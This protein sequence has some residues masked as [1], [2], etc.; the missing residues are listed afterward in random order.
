MNSL[1][2]IYRGLLGGA[3]ISV[4]GYIYLA[5]GGPVGAVLFAIGLLTVVHYSFLLYTGR[6]QNTF[7]T[8]EDAK[9]LIPVLACNV[10][11]CIIMSM[12]FFPTS[13]IV[14]TAT[15]IVAKRT[16]LPPLAV[17]G[18]AIGCGFIMT[19]AVAAAR[20]G[21]YWPLLLGVPGFILAGFIHSIADAFYISV[22]WRSISP[23]VIWKW[24][25]VVAGNFIGGVIPVFFKQNSLN[26][27]TQTK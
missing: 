7:D 19:I 21:N 2:F 11:G 25:I 6:I 3:C 18:R 10:A 22:A 13:E 23:E 5:V 24:L 9:Q 26:V 17:L 8:K 16:S 1:S 14:E 27:N 20:K 15:A 12:I 4:G